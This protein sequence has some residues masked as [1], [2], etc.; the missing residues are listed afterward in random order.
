MNRLLTLFSLS[1]R[2]GADGW[3]EPIAMMWRRW[4]EEIGRNPRLH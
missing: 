3:R 2:L 1:D 4:R